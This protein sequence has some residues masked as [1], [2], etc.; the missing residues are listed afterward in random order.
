MKKF[1][2]ELKRRNVFRVG[3]A[4]IVVSWVALQFV[5]VV[6]D[7]LNL[8]MWLPRVVIILLAIGC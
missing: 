6:Q 3:L 4:Y 7:P 5:D 8:P 1:L 2:T